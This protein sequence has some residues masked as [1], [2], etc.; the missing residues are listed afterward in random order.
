MELVLKTSGR[1]PSQVRILYPP[2]ISVSVFIV[3]NTK[4]YILLVLVVLFLGLF[5]FFTQ[6]TNEGKAYKD[7][8]SLC[9]HFAQSYLKT[10]AKNQ[11]NLGEQEWE[12]A[13]DVETELYNMCLLDLNSEALGSYTPSAIEKYKESQ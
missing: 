7:R 13:V 4:L 9:T 12:M 1:K 3:K 5:Y 10:I 6:D 2:P 11:P 8:Q